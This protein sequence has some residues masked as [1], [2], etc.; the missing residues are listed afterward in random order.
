MFQSIH[1]CVLVNSANCIVLQIR[2]DDAQVAEPAKETVEEDPQLE[3]KDD[4]PF[5]ADSDPDSSEFASFYKPEALGH[6]DLLLEFVDKYLGKKINLYKRLTTGHGDKIAFED[7]WMLFDTGMDI[8]SP[9]QEG[10]VEIIDANDDENIHITQR[11][12]LPQVY[13]VSATFGGIRL[14]KSLAPNY[15]ES[16]ADLDYA[17]PDFRQ[18]VFGRNNVNATIPRGRGGPTVTPSQAIKNKFSTLHVMCF[19]ID[20]DGSKFGTVTEVFPFKPYTGVVEIRA[21]DAYP[22]QYYNDE[23]S[24]DS[25]TTDLQSILAYDSLLER[26]RKFLGLTKITHMSYEGLTVASVKEEVSTVQCTFK[27]SKSMTAENQ[28]TGR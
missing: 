9:S 28:C 3:A 2:V 23:R 19:Y 17:D 5:A 4:L 16:Q 20:F 15:R 13:R 27:V 11:R 8:Y 26:G 25:S 24:P 22:V 7:L 1:R 21:L 18:S 10:G 14:S 12:S 6:F